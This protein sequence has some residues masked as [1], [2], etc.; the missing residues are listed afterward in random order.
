V[1][2]RNLHYAQCQ[3]MQGSLLGR[4]EVGRDLVAAL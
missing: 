2:I 1:Q 3:G 4:C